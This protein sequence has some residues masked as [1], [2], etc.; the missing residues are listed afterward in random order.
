M[1]DKILWLYAQGMST[2]EIVAAF[3]EWYGADITADLKRI[4]RSSTEDEALLELERFGESVSANI[5]VV[6]KSL[7]E[8]QYLI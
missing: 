7:A 2:S 8:P 3:D 4:Y 6:A 1:D 5:E